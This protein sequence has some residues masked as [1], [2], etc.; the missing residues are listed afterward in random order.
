[1][2]IE[3]TPAQEELRGQLRD[4]FGSLLTPDIKLIGRSLALVEETLQLEREVTHEMLESG[5]FGYARVLVSYF[6]QLARYCN[7]I[8]EIASHRLLRK[9]S[10]VATVQQ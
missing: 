7:I 2:R 9:T 6:G 3:Y 10:K 8:I 5:E 4:Y 1:M